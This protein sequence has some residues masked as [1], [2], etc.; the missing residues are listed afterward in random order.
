MIILGFYLEI[1]IQTLFKNKFKWGF[2]KP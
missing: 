1:P 2:C